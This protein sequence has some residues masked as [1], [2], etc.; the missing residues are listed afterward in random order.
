MHIEELQVFYTFLSRNAVYKDIL[1]Y[2]DNFIK[3]DLF[4]NNIDEANFHKRFLLC[5][6]KLQKK[7]LINDLD[8]YTALGKFFV[9]SLIDDLE[10]T[11]PRTLQRIDLFRRSDNFAALQ[12]RLLGKP[13]PKYDPQASAL[14]CTIQADLRKYVTGS[15]RFLSFFKKY[16]YKKPAQDLI[17]A[18]NYAKSESEIVSIISNKINILTKEFD[19]G[20]WKRYEKVPALRE[21]HVGKGYSAKNPFIVKLDSLVKL[22]NKNTKHLNLNKPLPS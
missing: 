16:P 1:C 20:L 2:F 12:Q 8:E 10:K 5:H 4:H 6:L 22:C 17:N 11:A 18:L 7:R 9:N 13:V 19:Y 21:A 15:N 3:H 14:A